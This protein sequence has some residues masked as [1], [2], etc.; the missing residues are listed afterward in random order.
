MAVKRRLVETI[1]D[2]SYLEGLT[3]RPL[4]ELRVMRDESREGEMEL[5]F[6]RRLCQGRS[7][8]LSAELD[9][10][11]GKVE[12]D[13][14]SRLPSILAA[15]GRQG[16]DSPLP[17]RAPDFSIP[18][19]ADIPR[20]RVEEIVGEQ[21]LTRLPTLAT[22]EIQQILRSLSEHEQS[23]SARRKAVQDVM[24][25]VQ[26]EIVRRYTSGEADPRSVSAG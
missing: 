12:G 10:R 17:S 16:S 23:V 3:T 19:N 18:R 1:T 13:L 6:E 4:D 5:S 15:E 14:M 7:D 9:R 24:D 20:R 25:K 8:I 11:S 26:A 2:P 22:E 21:T